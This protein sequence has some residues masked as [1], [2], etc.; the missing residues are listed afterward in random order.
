MDIII[1]ASNSKID[2]VIV[3]YKKITRDWQNVVS[4]AALKLK[5]KK[6]EIDLSYFEY[7]NT[8]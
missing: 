8:V 5:K 2:K 6:K 3:T 7:L 1:T 4:G